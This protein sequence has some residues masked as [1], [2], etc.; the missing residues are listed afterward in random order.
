MEG[1]GESND[2]TAIRKD[3]EFAFSV[4]WANTPIEKYRPFT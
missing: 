2:S 1:A 4:F 3:P